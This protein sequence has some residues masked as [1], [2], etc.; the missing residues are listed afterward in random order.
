MAMQ[1]ALYLADSKETASRELGELKRG[2]QR[3]FS[4]FVPNK[5]LCLYDLRIDIEQKIQD[6]NEYELLSKIITYPLIFLCS[7]RSDDEDFKDIYFISQLFFHLLFANSTKE[8]EGLSYKGI[9]YSS[10][11]NKG[12][13]NIVLPAKYSGKE[14]QEKGHS[15]LLYNMF[16]VSEHKVFKDKKYILLSIYKNAYIQS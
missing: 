1:P 2:K 16:T 10:T 11:K 4:E 13:Y 15:K 6:M 9:I 12:G 3:W 7:V 14:P 8:R 5:Q